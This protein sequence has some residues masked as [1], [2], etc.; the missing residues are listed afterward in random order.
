MNRRGRLG[1]A[2]GAALYMLIFCWGAIPFFL[3]KDVGQVI[4]LGWLGLPLSFLPVMLM[5]TET[6]VGT[7]MIL[8]GLFGIIQYGGIGYCLAWRRGRRPSKVDAPSS[9][10]QPGKSEQ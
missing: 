9:P 10:T 7:Q 6:S 1:F 4:T 2:I 8:V 3:G 5:P